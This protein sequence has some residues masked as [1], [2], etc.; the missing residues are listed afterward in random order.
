MEATELATDMVYEVVAPENEGE[1]APPVL[2][3]PDKVASTE[4]G[5][6]TATLYVV[7]LPS[8]AVTPTGTVTVAPSTIAIN[9]D[10]EPEATAT[11]LTVTDAPECVLAGVNAT[12][13]TELAMASV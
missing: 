8:C 6:D 13:S 9:D 2:V 7:V 11:L 4:S 10:A 12:E 1:K 5:R 3:N